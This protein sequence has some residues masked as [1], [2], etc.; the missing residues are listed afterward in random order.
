M[1][2]A[3]SIGLQEGSATAL[4]PTARGERGQRHMGKVEQ[5]AVQKLRGAECTRAWKQ[6]RDVPVCG[7]HRDW[8][9]NAEINGARRG[10][11]ST[12]GHTGRGWLKTLAPAPHPETTSPAPSTNPT[13]ALTGFPST[14]LVAD[15]DTTTEL[16]APRN[17]V[18]VF[19]VHLCV[20]L[21]LSFLVV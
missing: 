14:N 6:P 5:R 1:G 12:A 21:F 10:E 16:K 4:H 17:F 18:F 20:F 2:Q 7:W 11:Q 15:L 9:H 3:V 8:E 13:A 19:V